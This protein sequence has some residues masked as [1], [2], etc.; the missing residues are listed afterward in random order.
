M[1][2]RTAHISPDAKIGRNVT[3]GAYTQIFGDV[4]IEDNCI[5][6]NYC[7]IGEANLR[8]E[9][10]LVIPHGSTIRS[11]TVIYQGS[12]L[13]PQLETGHHVVIRE[14]TIAGENLRVGNFSDIEG[15][16]TIGDFCRFHGYTH[17]GK[18]TKIGDFVWIFSL[19]TATNDP[20]PPSLVSAPVTIQSGAVVCVG[21]TLM[22]GCTIGTG[23]FLS[24]GARV[25]GC[26]PDGAVVAPNG[27][28]VSHVTKLMNL[29]AGIRH[30]WMLHAKE[31]FP[32]RTHDRID[33]LYQQI[34]ASQIQ[35]TSKIT[36][37]SSGSPL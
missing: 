22:P 2:D 36:D 21:V 23:A 19:S 1:I 13:G 7:S 5:I 26:V 32:A 12:Q 9:I 29:S 14:G 11:H 25:M 24:A 6:Q 17:I 10:G 15:D 18:G 37:A 20:L 28:I 16:C 35:P 27:E 33:A 8:G 4:V 31:I 34:K 3:I 30:P